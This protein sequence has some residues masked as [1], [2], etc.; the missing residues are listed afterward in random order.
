MHVK[1]TLLWKC[2]TEKLKTNWIYAKST[3]NKKAHTI[4][5]LQYVLEQIDDIN[6]IKIMNVYSE[7]EIK[8]N[9]GRKKV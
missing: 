9:I 5:K 1:L 7:R 2:C 8:K 6:S 3:K 4:T